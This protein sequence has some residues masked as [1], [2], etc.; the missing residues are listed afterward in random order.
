MMA[1]RCSAVRLYPTPYTLHPTPYTLDLGGG[2]DDGWALLGGA[3]AGFHQR[4]LRCH[5]RLDRLFQRAHLQHTALSVREDP[6]FRARRAPAAA[7]VPPP[8][9]PGARPDLRLQVFHFAL[10]RL[11]G[12]DVF[13]LQLDRGRHR[14]LDLLL[15]DV[16]QIVHLRMVHG[17]PGSIRV[18][19][20]LRRGDEPHQPHQHEHLARNSGAVRPGKALTACG[21]R[22][23]CR[24][25]TLARTRSRH[26]ASVDEGF[27]LPRS[28]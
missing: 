18:D 16:S 25:P 9:P 10:V 13:C 2:N 19:R 6:L 3:L 5:Q 12:F 27:F 15:D 14:P 4:L 28:G 24:R 26:M 11:A 7:V 22:G 21:T 1:G 8:P 23:I 17:Y 20:H